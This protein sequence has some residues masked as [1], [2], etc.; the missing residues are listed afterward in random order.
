MLIKFDDYPVH[1]THELLSYLATSERNA[2]ARYW[3]NAYDG[4][5]AGTGSLPEC[6]G[7]D[8]R[9]VVGEHA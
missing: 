9:Q 2:Y 7:C 4:R 1:Q 5:A 8:G 3:Y 6:D